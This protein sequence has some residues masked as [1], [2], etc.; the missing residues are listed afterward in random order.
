M[1]LTN[2][3]ECNDVVFDIDMSD[4]EIEILT[5][6]GEEHITSEALIQ[7]AMV[8]ILTTQLNRKALVE[9]AEL[10]ND[11]C[12]N[13]AELGCPQDQDVDMWYRELSLD[14]KCNV[15]THLD[16][17]NGEVHERFDSTE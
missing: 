11:V 9:R 5:K 14:E 17:I 7:F 13:A 4:K 6:Y 12:A 2:E 15:I 3:R 1:K 10:V 8:D 16:T